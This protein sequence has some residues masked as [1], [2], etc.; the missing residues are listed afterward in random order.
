VLSAGLVVATLVGSAV[1]GADPRAVHLVYIRG[2][3]AERCPSQAELQQGVIARLGRDPFWGRGARPVWITITRSGAQLVA[4]IAAQAE[5]GG[6]AQ[7]RAV[8]SRRGE[9]AELASAVELALAIAIDPVAVEGRPTE[10][11][12]PVAEPLVTPSAPAVSTAPPPQPPEAAALVAAQPHA[13]P[14]ARTV[15]DRHW[16]VGAELLLSA[17][18]GPRT[19]P[20]FALAL[21]ARRGD[22]SLALEGRADYPIEMPVDGGA[23]AAAPLLA[24]VVPCY[25]VR[26]LAACAVT[27]AGVLVGAAR[28][29]PGARTEVTPYWAAGA[30]LAAE[31][32]VGARF[33]LGAHFDL[34]ATLTPTHLQV[35][36]TQLWQTPVLSGTFGLSAIERFW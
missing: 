16:F 35:D 7:V 27:T 15:R 9:C 13:T 29:L 11:P 30:R 26:S 21:G 25:H 8:T 3:G 12:G 23:I 5:D 2:A 28:G 17:G 6:A 36:Q 33:A 19:S 10:A 34:M 32:P 18:T 31:L 4:T 20:G 22:W 1:A 14:E 24:A